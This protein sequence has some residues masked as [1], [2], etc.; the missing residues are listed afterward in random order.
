M[1]RK[2]FVEDLN[3]VGPKA[4]RRAQPFNYRSGSA[5]IN[6]RMNLN[7]PKES[8]SESKE[9]FSLFTDIAD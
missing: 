7:E 5:W 4:Q 2:L 1:R 8:N 6:P 3:S 9:K